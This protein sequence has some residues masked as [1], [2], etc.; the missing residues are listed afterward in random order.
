MSSPMSCEHSLGID[1][2]KQI[3]NKLES[4]ARNELPLL[5]KEE[6]LNKE[7][8]QTRCR[9]R[10]RTIVMDNFSKQDTDQLLKALEEGIQP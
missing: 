5:C 9:D 6:D 10:F 2:Y 7:F 8:K 3:N 4:F 1:K